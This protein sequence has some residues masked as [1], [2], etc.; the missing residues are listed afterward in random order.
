MK[1][2]VIALF[3]QAE[4][5]HQSA[6][7]LKARGFDPSSVHVAQSA[8]PAD[9]EVPP[10]SDIESGPLSGLL[11]RLSLLFGVEEPH[12]AHYVEAVR[13]GGNVVQVDAADEAQAMAARD[14]LLE[15]G[16]AN[17]DD[18]VGEWEQAGWKSPST[19]ADAAPAGA[20]MHR[21]E[22]SIG[23]VRVYGHAAGKSFDDFASEFRSDYEARYAGEGG[24]YGDFDPA[25]RL[26][27][28]LATDA[29][30][31]GC[32]WADTEVDAR[33]QWERSHPQTAWER[34]KNVVR[35]AFERV[36]RA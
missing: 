34:M 23:G 33:A 5:A 22:A 30:Y 13:R 36:S 15:L 20:A 10:A 32:S 29:R 12:V 17:I 19:Q 27:H 28:A 18:R 35:H 9:P 6:E 4:Q 31:A 1:H 25:Y 11:H 26:G 8:G 24:A 16:A 21:Q 3:D 7:A 2:T 14:A